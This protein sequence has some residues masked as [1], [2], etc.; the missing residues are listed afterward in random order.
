MKGSLYPP[1]LTQILRE[2]LRELRGDQDLTQPQLADRLGI[3]RQTLG[4]WETGRSSPMHD[5]QWEEWAAALGYRLQIGYRLT[6]FP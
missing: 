2:R 5:R 3:H 4:N 6:R 1:G